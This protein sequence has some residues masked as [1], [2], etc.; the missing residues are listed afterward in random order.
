MGSEI[1]IIILAFTIIISEQIELHKRIQKL[2]T[3]K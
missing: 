1:I 2:E 3:K